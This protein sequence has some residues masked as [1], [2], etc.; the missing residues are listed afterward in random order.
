MDR[1]HVAPCRSIIRE[2]PI[3]WSPPQREMVARVLARHPAES[4]R[5][6]QAAREILPVARQVDA[7]ARA[8]KLL[9]LEGRFVVTKRPLEQRWYQHVAVHAQE[10][11]V[12]AL[13]GV[14][15]TPARSYLE[16]HW[17]YPES[18]DWEDEISRGNA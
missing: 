9:P 18:L 13:T 11:V 8:R 3:S 5:C 15:G 12:D 10:H 14:E 6:G 2:M 1:W 4:N 16:Q 7:G 17:M